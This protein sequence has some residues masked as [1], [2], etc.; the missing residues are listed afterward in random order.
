MYGHTTELEKLEQH[1]VRR[2]LVNHFVGSISPVQSL[3]IRGSLPVS[4]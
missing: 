4:W 1:Q 3:P 2:W